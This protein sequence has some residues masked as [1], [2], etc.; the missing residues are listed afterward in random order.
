MKTVTTKI[1][2]ISRASSK[3]SEEPREVTCTDSG[4]HVGRLNFTPGAAVAPTTV[5]AVLLASVIA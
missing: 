1:S 4:S 3:C 5:S 2:M